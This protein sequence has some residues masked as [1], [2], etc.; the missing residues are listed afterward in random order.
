M[1]LFG[2]WDV[3]DWEVTNQVWAC[4]PSSEPSTLGSGSSLA[5]PPR[6]AHSTVYDPVEGQVILFGGTSFSGE[7]TPL[8]DYDDTWAYDSKSIKWT[9]LH[10]SGDLPSGRGGHA[11]VYDPEGKQVIL[12][13][14]GSEASGFNDTWSYDPAADS[15]TELAPAG[16]VPVARDGH[17]MVYDPKSG[18][19]ILFGGEDGATE[20][21]DTWAYDLKANE[22]TELRPRGAR[23]QARCYHTMVYDPVGERMILFGGSVLSGEEGMEAVG[24][25]DAWAYDPQANTW[26]ELAPPRDSPSARHFTGAT[27]DAAGGRVILFGGYDDGSYEYLN[28]TWRYDPAA[29]AWAEFA[30]E[31]AVPPA[32]ENHTLVYDSRRDKV[33][34]F[35]G[36]GPEAGLF[37]DIWEY[38]PDANTW[39][40]LL[41]STDDVKETL[42]VVS[43][44]A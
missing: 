1:L 32:R 27:Y 17:S 5:P 41:P 18:K 9:E 23:P 39:I 29:N 42:L 35:G 31:K 4:K 19:V 26:T 38:D 15:W 20:L 37:N 28:D 14:G 2:G 40:E 6:L 44:L 34:L 43:A 33:I 12:F 11:M 3:A 7:E 36:W 16:K 8:V 25:D 13:G 21:S 22:W 10:P 30:P 24:I